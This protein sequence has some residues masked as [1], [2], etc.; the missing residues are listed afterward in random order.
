MNLADRLRTTARRLPDK[1]ALVLRPTS[2]SSDTVSYG[3]LDARV[4]H[5]AAAFAQAGLVKGDRVGLLLG[6]SE[7]FVEA[8]YGALRA[9]LTVVP[10]NVTY[11]ANEIA[12]ILGDSEAAAVVVGQAFSDSLNGLGETLPALQLIIVAGASSPP[13]G[14]QT[15]RLRPRISRCCSTP[16]EPPACP[17][18]R[19]CR[20]RTSSRTTTRWREPA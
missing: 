14:T 13:M 12:Q 20:T 4:D 2:G 10:M 17:R 16:L 7:H 19:C 9:G 18:A 15:W 8:F 1:A 3:Q 5:A 11:T 6:N